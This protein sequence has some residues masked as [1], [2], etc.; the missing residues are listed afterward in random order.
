MKTGR[1][2]SSRDN[3]LL[4]VNNMFRKKALWV[5]TQGTLGAFPAKF[6]GNEIK[7]SVTVD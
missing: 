3:A 7:Y 2:L 1:I 4:F 5:D 6:K